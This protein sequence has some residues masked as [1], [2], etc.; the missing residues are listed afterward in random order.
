MVLCKS[1]GTLLC[2]VCIGRGNDIAGQVGTLETAILQFRFP[3]T[4]FKKYSPGIAQ[5]VHT[6]S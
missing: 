2:D 6:T 4:H 3:F 1:A 5:I